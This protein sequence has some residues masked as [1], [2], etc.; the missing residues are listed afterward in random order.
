MGEPKLK[1]YCAHNKVEDLS[2]LIKH[3]KNSNMHPHGQIRLLA[4]I[5]KSGWRLPIT[6]SNR[7]GYIVRGHGRLEAALLAGFTKGPVDYQDYDSES[8]ELADLLADNRIAELAERD[9]VLL[10][11]TLLEIDDGSF[12]MDLTGFDNDE[13]ERLMLQYPVGDDFSVDSPEYNT[14]EKTTIKVTVYCRDLENFVADMTPLTDKY[15]GSAI[16]VKNI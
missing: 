1:I 10:K 11:E 7:S 16:Y 3:P 14:E 5:L 4:K 8:E 9:N 2:T 15:K 6:V 13:L 12:D